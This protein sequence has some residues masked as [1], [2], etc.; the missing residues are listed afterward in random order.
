MHISVVTPALGRDVMYERCMPSLW[1][2]TLQP[3]EHIIVMDGPWPFTHVVPRQHPIRVRWL[4][5][6]RPERVGLDAFRLG[7]ELA[8]GDAIFL[9]P[10]DDFLEPLALELLAAAL[11][12]QAADFAY[13]RVAMMYDEPSPRWVCGDSPPAYGHITNFLFRRELFDPAVDVHPDVN[14]QYDWQFVESWLE[15]SKRYAFVPLVLQRHY[16]DHR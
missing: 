12:E 14:P 6:H 13:S 2:Q 5:E 10:D 7:C 3:F 9:M 8:R 16:V 11:G 15:R 4:P 1:G